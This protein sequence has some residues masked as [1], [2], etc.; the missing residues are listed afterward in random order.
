MSIRL[1]AKE[2]YRL[3]RESEKIRK[4]IETAPLFER[5]RLEEQLR[6][7]NAELEQARRTLDGAID[8]K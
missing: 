8:R 5:A 4:Q 3:L 6:K 2:M 1:I 7:I